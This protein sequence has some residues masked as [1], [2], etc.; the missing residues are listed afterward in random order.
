[1]KLDECVKCGNLAE[2]CGYDPDQGW[3]CPNCWLCLPSG[4]LP[5]SGS[6]SGETIKKLIRE[7]KVE[8]EDE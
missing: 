7:A 1:M 5:P 2:K 3:L 6:L 4:S 8:G